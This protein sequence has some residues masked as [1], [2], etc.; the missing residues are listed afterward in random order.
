MSAR[1]TKGDHVSSTLQ[2]LGIAAAISVALAGL[3]G[4]GAKSD[5]ELIASAKGH[6]QNND[7]PAAI[8]ELKSA[9]Q[10]NPQS[11]E[12]RFLLGRT[13]FESGDMAAAQIELGKAHDLRWDDNAVLPLLA[14]AMVA[15][16][17]AKQ[18]AD[19]YGRFELGDRVAGAELRA[20][21]ALAHAALGDSDRS[22]AAV[23]QALRLDPKNI[24]ARLQEARLL[25]RTESPRQTL[26]RVDGIL[27]DAPGNANAWL[28]KGNVLRWSLGDNDGAMAAY[29]SALE[30]EPRHLPAYAALVPLLLERSDVEGLRTMVAAMKQVLPQHPDTR[31]YDAQVAL[32]D[33]DVKRARDGVQQLLK[34]APTSVRLLQLAGA[35]EFRE[36][37]LL[38][39]ESFLN[40]AIQQEPRQGAARRLLAQ[41]HLRAGQPAKALQAIK[42]VLEG[43]RPDA[44]S[45]AAAAEAYLQSGDMA[46]AERYFK[47][48]AA[49]DPRDP[50]VSTALALTQIAKGQT[51]DGFAQLEHIATQDP[52]NYA[53]LALI[54]ARLRVGQADAALAATGRLEKKM[55]GQPL[56]HLLRGRILG[57]RG[58]A[59]GAR[60][61]YTRA[62]ELD[63]AYFPAVA[64]L[65]AIDF[66]ENKPQD[67]IK[68]FEALRAQDPRD[69]RALLAIADL[70]QRTG[71]GAA[72]IASLLAAAVKANPGEAAPRLML[73]EHYLGLGDHKAALTAANEAVAAVPDDVRLLDALGVAQLAVGDTQ[74]ALATFGKVAAAQPE[75]PGPQMRMADTY[76]AMKNPDAAM[77]AL[78]RALKAAPEHLPAQQRLVQVALA[79]QRYD[80]AL[81][82]AREV[83]RQRPREAAGPL[84]ESEVH[85]AQKQWPAALAATRVAL[86]RQPATLVAVRQHALL[87]LAGRQPEA[88]RF[89]ASWEAEHP[90]DAD[91]QNHLG[92][93]ALDQGQFAQAEARFRK[94]IALRPN[95]AVAHNNVAWLLV[96]QGKPGAVAVAE[97][98]LQLAPGNASVLD[99]LAGALAADKQLPRAVQ[100]QREAVAKAPEVPNYRL[101]LARLLLANGDKAAAR[102][103]LESLAKLG[104]SYRGQD[105]VTRLLKTL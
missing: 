4:C 50:K 41:T 95:D 73:V 102:T 70:K 8:I 42:P 65:A 21:V 22:Q 45:L 47:R 91:F 68:R 16:G 89:A 66:A 31:Y 5:T 71:A 34:L 9:L 100:T 96:R 64:G 30:A 11:A 1:P 77:Q 81:Q 97:R 104:P 52:G 57:Q 54:S 29:R 85:S 84:L 55:P 82:V 56:P 39:A 69:Y 105:E 103:E 25:T 88:E 24:T 59:P 35:I 28:L 98:A 14:K 15:R 92:G 2:R 99:T 74:Q 37:R 40:R 75:L 32:L 76:V 62:A 86:Q 6:L 48:A 38:L 72:E 27:A 60:A 36:G 51:D 23:D 7:R 93:A 26:E 87:S 80:E 12:A 18:V 19:L 58:D 83:G 67:A 78:R 13:L 79:S 10:G 33:G 49:I 90:K 61:A 3:V 17:E 101:G 63:P 20:Q 53:D 44:P 46:T 43:P 94:V